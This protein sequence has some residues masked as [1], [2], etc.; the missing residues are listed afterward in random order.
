M[1]RDKELPIQILAIDDDEQML[2]VMVDALSDDGVEVHSAKDAEEALQ[3]FDAH[4]PQIILADLMLPGMGGME[5]LERVM[6][7]DPSVDFVLVTGHYT[8]ESAV[9]AIQKGAAEYLTKPLSIE[10]LRSKVRGF[11]EGRKK[12]RRAYALDHELM[13]T[14]QFEG[15]IGRSPHMLDVFD[16]IQRVAPHFRTV[17]IAGPTGTGK[18]LVAKALHKLSPV[19]SKPFVVCNCAAVVETLFESELFG[20]VKGAFTGATQ[21]KVGLF[22][23]ANGGTVFL[24]E[25]GEMPLAAQAKLLR[26]LQNQEVQRV[27][28][29]SVRKIDV[30]VIAATNRDLSQQVIDKQFRED[31][32]YRLSMVEIK[33]PRLAERRDDLPLLQ[34]HFVEHFS[35]QYDKTVRGISR[36]A[37]TMLSEYW[38]PGNVRELENVIGNACMMTLDDF[39]DIADLPERLITRS[40]SDNFGEDLVTFEELQRRYAHKVLAKVSGNKARAAEILGVSRTT[41]YKLLGSDPETDAAI[42]QA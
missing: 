14:Y 34:R 7:S 4:R 23:Y 22:E 8:A 40:P 35:K 21:D 13:T 2:A 10:T 28:S 25:I 9:Q 15:I 32:F 30:H 31:L 6:Q 5:L 27:G 1:D 16:K 39:I 17:L 29:P 38:W 11:V 42:K 12:R 36:R 19:A 41:L 26:V 20:Y 24:D 37:Q 3:L 33:L 18:E